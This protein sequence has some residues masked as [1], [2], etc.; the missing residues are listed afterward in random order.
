MAP[1]AALGSLV[2]A[3]EV[4]IPAAL[5]MHAR[6]GDFLY[7]SY[8]F[9]DAFHPSF[10][11]DIPLK[12]GRL[13]PHKG[14]VATDYIGIDPGPHPAVTPNYRNEVLCAIIRRRPHTPT[15]H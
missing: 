13:V 5:E 12:T 9:L 8:G 3:P 11:Y 14:W 10:K 2:F 6:Y 4:V 15:R 7:S 1:T